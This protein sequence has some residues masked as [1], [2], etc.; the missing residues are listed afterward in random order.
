MLYPTTVDVIR[1]VV[2]KAMPAGYVRGQVVCQVVVD[3]TGVGRPV[4]DS[5]KGTGLGA[6][7]WR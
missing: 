1:H 2:R 6:K 3:A 5:M 7:W 4:V